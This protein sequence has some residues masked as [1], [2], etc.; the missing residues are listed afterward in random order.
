MFLQIKKFLKVKK[1][2]MTLVRRKD[3]KRENLK[4]TIGLYLIAKERKWQGS[5]KI[6]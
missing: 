4:I 2:E 3:K 1:K 6:E 5:N